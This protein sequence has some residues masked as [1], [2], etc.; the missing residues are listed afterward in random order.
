MIKIL[1]S[2]DWHLDAPMHLRSQHQSALLRKVLAGIPARIASLCKEQQCHMML[3]SGDLLDGACTAQTVQNLKLAFE[4]VGVPV[5]ITPGNHDF[6]GTDS[7]WLTEVWPENVHIFTRPAIESVVLEDLDCRVYGAG[8]TSMDC[9]GLLAGF[10]ADCPEKYAVGILHADP[11][12]VTS[13]Y[14]PVTKQQ[15][16]NSNLHYLALGHI[17]KGDSFRADKTLC[18]WPGCPMGKGYDEDGEKGV[19][20]VTLAET[21]QA[22]F[23]PLDVP[24]FYDLEVPAGEDPSAAMDA[25]LPPAGSHDF[26]RVTF[27]G[28][29]TPLDTEALL[30]P[31]FPNLV[32]R[33]R[34]TPPIDVWG[35]AGEDTFE[36]RYF[37]LLQNALQDA[38]EDTRQRICLAAELSRKILDGQEVV[39]P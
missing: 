27:T 14:C 12:Q 25:L 6:L 36:G 4:E 35:S 34:T 13:P 7:P 22:Q 15:V 17:H 16:Q 23:I 29:S 3:L 18:A 26:Y 37:K 1:H 32:L 19:L 10:T 11:T 8:F 24:R 21:A 38:D 20:I 31:D 5:F 30:R 9:P 33:D 39:L 28:P 2:A